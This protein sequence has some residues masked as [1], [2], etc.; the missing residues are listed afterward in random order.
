MYDLIVVGARVSGSPTAMLAAKAG[1]K[2][3]LV[4][5]KS[6][7]SDTLSTNYIHQPG[8]ARL[9][10]WG[11]LDRVIDS[12]C[13]A[14]PT[15]RFEAYGVVIKGGISNNYGQ[16]NAYAPRRFI[17]DSILIEAARE[18]GVE[19]RERNTVTRLIQENGRIVGV[20]IKG[21]DG[22]VNIERAPLVVGADGMHS[23][24]AHLA[25]ARYTVSDP[26]LT[27]AYYTFW[28]NLDAG[29][30]L[31]EGEK[32]WVGAVPTHDSIL[33]ATYFPQNQFNQIRKKA[34]QAHLDAI[35]MTA[36]GLFDRMQ[37]ATQTGKLWGTGEQK[38]FFRQASGPG[39]VLVGDSGHHKDSITA[40]GI[41][42]A[43][44]Q[45]ELLISR[46]TNNTDIFN[47]DKLD[48]SLTRYTDD[49]D[50]L[51]MPGYK[52]TL[53]VAQLELEEQEYRRKILQAVASDSHCTHLYFDVVAGIRP[54]R[55]LE[56][57]LPQLESTLP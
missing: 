26:T 7:P 2:T 49:R 57:A 10:R 23:K 30:E 3:L 35:K 32:S 20:E 15:T 17:L 14:I 43:F 46:I 11:L 4:D 6:F 22:K 24:V 13:P 54:Y 29:Y 27:C 1:L 39:W 52:S 40:R 31:Y 19:V 47:L 38:N 8:C 12:G 41:T 53:A 5:R 37:S 55:D 42:D 9:D 36:P 44:V 18:S 25:D 28:E 21:P 56:E 48:A 50:T 45:A 16:I 34:N 33:V 51:M